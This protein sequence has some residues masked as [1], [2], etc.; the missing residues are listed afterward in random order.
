MKIQKFFQDYGYT[1]VK[2]II[3]HIAMS[4]F[5]LMLYIPTGAN[6]MLGG[7]FGIVSVV[8]YFFNRRMGVSSLQG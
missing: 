3:T 2:L 7:I 6:P 5:G 1:A 4:I 8:F